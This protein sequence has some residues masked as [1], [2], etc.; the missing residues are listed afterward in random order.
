MSPR[1]LQRRLADDGASFGLI[2]DEVRA[3]LAATYLRESDLS[4]AEVA[5]ILQYSQTSA[6][7]RAF[8]RWRDLS[9]RRARNRAR[10]P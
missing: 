8:R 7:S 3:D 6:L 4:V 5:E 1:T 10:A 2:L 9:P